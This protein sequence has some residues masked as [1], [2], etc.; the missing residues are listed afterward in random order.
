MPFVSR[1]TRGSAPLPE[2]SVYYRMAPLMAFI[3]LHVPLALLM[4]Q[5]S[6]VSL[7][8]AVVTFGIGL[9]IAALD[10]NP[11]RLIYV[12][13]YITGAEVLWRMTNDQIFWEFAKY[14]SVALFL[15]AIC[16]MAQW[17]IPVLATLYFALLVPSA[18]MTVLDMPFHEARGQISFNLSGALA[19]FVSAWFFS[20]VQ[21][22]LDRLQRLLIVIIAPVLGIATLAIY[23]ILTNPDLTFTHESNADLSGGF[24]PN[25]VSSILGLAAVLGFICVLD[26]R[27]GAAFRLLLIGLM[28]LFAGQSALT[29]SRGGLLTAS[30]SIAVAFVYLIRDRAW[31]LPMMITAVAVVLAIHYVI[32]PRLDSFTGGNL[33]QRFHEASLTHRGDISLADLQI[34]RDHPLLG[35]GPGQATVAR[36]A[37]F[38]K[39]V[40]HTEFTRV[41]AEHGSFGALA[42]ILLAVACAR[43][44]LRAE[45]ARE[46]AILLA[47]LTWSA[48]F[49][50]NS[51]MRLMAP[52]LL[53]GVTFATLISD[54]APA[55]RRAVEPRRRQLLGTTRAAGSPSQQAV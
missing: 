22:P 24:G 14:A 15:T 3:L 12:A 50:M 16:R 28:L 46:K 51:A 25:Q 29:F 1:I 42:L 53:F 44:V 36:Q 13:A 23:G 6:F 37:Y 55:V 33:G 20:A 54:E 18:V 40:A 30:L 8:H 21:L 26:Y 27:W 39:A 32:F 48:M 41:V 5:Y 10:R 9:K 34:W 52:S 47:L 43:N 45:T 19:L 35:V 49:M 38:G 17:R 11:Q 31:R 7:L 2:P 4:R